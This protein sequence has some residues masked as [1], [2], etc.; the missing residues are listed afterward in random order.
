MRISFSE[1]KHI[2]ATP[3]L[4]LLAPDSSSNLTLT[5]EC[6]GVGGRQLFRGRYC[7]VRPQCHMSDKVIQLLIR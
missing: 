6:Q 1:Q 4:P 5:L 3:P 2:L 7:L